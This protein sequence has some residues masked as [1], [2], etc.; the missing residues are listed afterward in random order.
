MP[1]FSCATTA[2][3]CFMSLTDISRVPN[4]QCF[5]IFSRINVFFE[6]PISGTL[7]KSIPALV[8]HYSWARL[9]VSKCGASKKIFGQKKCKNIKY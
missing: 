2:E 4:Q 8:G 5:D 6:G 1:S 7:E 9:S 3:V